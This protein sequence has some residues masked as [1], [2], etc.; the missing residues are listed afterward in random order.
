MRRE[1]MADDRLVIFWSCLRLPMARSK[2][3]ETV[4]PQDAEFTN[5]TLFRS[6]RGH[7]FI[8]LLLLI[9]DLAKY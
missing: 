3:I 8:E 4:S 7:C 9:T 6:R 5:F 1:E 2:P